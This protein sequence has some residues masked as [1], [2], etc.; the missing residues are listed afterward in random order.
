[1]SLKVNTIDTPFNCSIKP[2]RLVFLDTAKGIG[3]ALVLLSHSNGF[4]FGK[5]FL[6]A[7]YMQMFFIIAGYTFKH[8]TNIKKQVCQRCKRLIV[9]YFLY[10]FVL[11]TFKVCIENGTLKDFLCMQGGGIYSRYCLFSDSRAD[12]IYFMLAFNSPLWFLTCMA[13]TCILFY[14]FMYYANN[15]KKK[16]IG[17][18]LFLTVGIILDKLPILLPWSLDTAFVAVILMYIGYI[19][20]VSKIFEARSSLRFLCFAICFISYHMSAC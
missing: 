9:P 13:V 10:N 5:T 15:N 17:M 16:V 18:T 2:G 19:L 7:Y 20:N 11:I 14:F 12:N 4:L 1:M 6:T 8:S 3:I